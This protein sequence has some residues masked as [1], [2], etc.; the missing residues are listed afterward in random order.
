MIYTSNEWIYSR[1]ITLEYLKQDTCFIRVNI[2]ATKLN[3][4]HNVFV[5]LKKES[6]H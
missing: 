2:S 5:E 3:C 4:Q 1:S 6:S